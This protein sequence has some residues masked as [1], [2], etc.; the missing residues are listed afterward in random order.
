MTYFRCSSA[1]WSSGHFAQEEKSI[2]EKTP[3]T[4]EELED[5]ALIVPPEVKE[6]PPDEAPIVNEKKIPI[7]ALHSEEESGENEAAPVEEELIVGEA[8]EEMPADTLAH[9]PKVVSEAGGADTALNES[10]DVLGYETTTEPGST[11]GED[12]PCPKRPKLDRATYDALMED[13]VVRLH[14]LA[15]LWD[16]SFIPGN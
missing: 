5:E 16:K 6:T 13:L 8:E 10:D 3:P 1:E 4:S 9:E 7:D 15:I 14:R 12:V 2:G 11:T